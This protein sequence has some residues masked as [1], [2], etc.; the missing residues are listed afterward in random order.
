MDPEEV[1]RRLGSMHCSEGSGQFKF[2]MSTEAY[3]PERHDI[4]L[5]ESTNAAKLDCLVGRPSN[6]EQSVSNEYSSKETPE[7]FEP[8]AY[9][10]MRNDLSSYTAKFLLQPRLVIL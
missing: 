5:D 9:S 1:T 3:A 10:G 8:L 7:K 2:W 6:E 4:W